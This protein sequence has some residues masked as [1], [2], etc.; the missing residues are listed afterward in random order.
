M[1]LNTLCQIVI[2]WRLSVEDA[3]VHSKAVL[4]ALQ[5]ASVSHATIL[6]SFVIKGHLLRVLVHGK[7]VL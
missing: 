2:L 3:M 6:F 7:A 5:K 4:L 1:T